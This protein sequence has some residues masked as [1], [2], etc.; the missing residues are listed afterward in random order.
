[1]PANVCTVE[2]SS[3]YGRSL[4]H[5]MATQ[6]N[7]YGLRVRTGTPLERHSLAMSLRLSSG[8]SI[9]QPWFLLWLCHLGIIG[10]DQQSAMEP[11]K[12]SVRYGLVEQR[13]VDVPRKIFGAKTDDGKTDAFEKRKQ[14]RRSLAVVL[15]LGSKNLS[16]VQSSFS[17]VVLCSS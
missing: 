15:R 16:L 12:D 11:S 17:I 1:M 7:L 13:K 5:P 4:V 8:S 6:D 2:S 14:S 9:V 3:M 10:T